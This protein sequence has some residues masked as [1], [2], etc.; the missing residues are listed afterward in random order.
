MQNQQ[1]GTQ[2]QPSQSKP[3]PQQQGQET[4]TPQQGG[5]SFT[6]WASI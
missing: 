2:S 6:D 1:M 5:T 3:Q 4:K